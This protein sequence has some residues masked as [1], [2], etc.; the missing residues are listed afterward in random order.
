MNRQNNFFFKRLAILQKSITF[1]RPK[2]Q[3]NGSV[4]QL[5]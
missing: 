4:V 2:H 3:A 1:A 5:G